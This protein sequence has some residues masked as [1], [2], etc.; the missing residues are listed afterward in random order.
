[1]PNGVITRYTLYIGYGSGAVDVF[2][3]DGWSTSYNI[4]NLLPY[5]R[6]TVGMT[7]STRVGE[8]PSSTIDIRTAQLRMLLAQGWKMDIKF[9][10]HSLLALPPYCSLLPFLSS[11]LF[12]PSH[13][14][15]LLAT[16]T[17]L[18][19]RIITIAIIL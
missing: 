13:A 3:T 16:Y 11:Y 5:Q 1:M 18:Y 15:S 9:E 10:L 8:G 2:N 14:F 17:I 7:A 19:T 4:T 6:V 12:V